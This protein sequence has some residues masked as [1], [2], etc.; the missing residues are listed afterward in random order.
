VVGQRYSDLLIA[1]TRNSV[2]V[3]LV[4]T[5]EL[6]AA[7]SS[8]GDCADSMHGMSISW[9][10]HGAWKGHSTMPCRRTTNHSATKHSSTAGHSDAPVSG[11]TIRYHCPPSPDADKKLDASIKA[12]IAV[13]QSSRKPGRCL[14]QIYHYLVSVPPT[15][16]GIT[17]P[18]LPRRCSE[19][20]QTS[21]LSVTSLPLPGVCATHISRHN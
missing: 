6:A 11:S 5:A 3:G 20:S 7:A 15:S 14:E 19:Q 16:V 9:A 12:E 18:R 4:M 13:F 17:R 8:A 21:S 2:G 1:A 10:P